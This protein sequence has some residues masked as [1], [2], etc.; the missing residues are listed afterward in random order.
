M[1]GS[2]FLIL[3]ICSSSYIG[4]KILEHWPMPKSKE[5]LWTFDTCHLTFS[6]TVIE[7]EVS[8]QKPE[9]NINHA[10]LSQV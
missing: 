3:V 4:G 8:G 9:Y 10:S 6:I 5:T 2:F 7:V 1:Q